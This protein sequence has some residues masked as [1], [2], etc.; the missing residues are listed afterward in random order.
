M[1][2]L[3]IV[4]MG[5]FIGSAARYGVYLLTLKNFADKPY[6]GTLIVNLVGCL[7]I[8]LLSGGLLKTN[9]QT[10]LFLIAGLCGGFTT[11]SAFAL[12]GLKLIRDGLTLQ[13]F[14]YASISMI[15]GLAVCFLGF[16]AANRL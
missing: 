5:G 9:Q 8:G 1:K 16:Y 14:L 13:F 10:S 3:L 12:D 15:G 2:D 7:L 6:T 4:G 11:F